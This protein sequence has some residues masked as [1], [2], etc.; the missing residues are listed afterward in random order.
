M[1][2][3]EG[4]WCDGSHVAAAANENKHMR[5]QAIFLSTLKLRTHFSQ[6]FA[7]LQKVSSFW[8]QRVA[9]C[10]CIST[11]Y[12]KMLRHDLFWD[13]RL[14]PALYCCRYTHII[15]SK[16]WSLTAVVQ[17]API[18]RCWNWSYWKGQRLEEHS[19]LQNY[20]TGKVFLRAKEHVTLSEPSIF[21]LLWAFLV[22]QSMTSSLWELL[23]LWRN[24]FSLSCGNNLSVL[25]ICRTWALSGSDS[26]SPTCNVRAPRKW[27]RW[28]TNVLVDP[29]HFV[30]RLPKAG[31]LILR[32]FYV[33][34]TWKG[35]IFMLTRQRPWCVFVIDIMNI[36]G[37]LLWGYAYPNGI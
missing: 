26:W 23:H 3:A 13:V 15:K 24:I 21:C 10:L 8:M 22:S 9:T 6:L 14:E 19:V 33:N 11:A 30:F 32:L 17:V 28:Y 5:K 37:F 12:S 7:E 25:A 27:W 20:R 35:S 29:Y 2:D 1:R 31:R 16:A 36:K 34:Y 4:S 18:W